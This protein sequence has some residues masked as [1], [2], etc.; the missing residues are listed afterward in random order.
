MHLIIC[1]P[2]VLSSLYALY[3]LWAVTYPNIVHCLLAVWRSTSTSWTSSFT[4]STCA[5]LIQNHYLN[6]SCAATNV[7]ILTPAAF[8]ISVLHSH[9]VWFSSH[10]LFIHL[11]HPT[12]TSC[13]PMLVPFNLLFLVHPLYSLQLPF[14]AHLCA[15]QLIPSQA[16]PLTSNFLFIS[17]FATKYHAPQTC[18]WF[19]HSM[20]NHSVSFSHHSLHAQ[21]V[22]VNLTPCTSSGF[23]FL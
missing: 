23:Y 21:H 3:P 8:Q 18:L 22:L 11:H 15:I 1:T 4:F 5:I 14:D 10:F 16:V 2:I 13:T 19:N 17:N 9:C 12:Y 20:Q 6:T 7:C